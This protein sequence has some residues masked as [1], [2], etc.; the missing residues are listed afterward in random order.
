[1]HAKRSI[2]RATG[3]IIALLCLLVS[4][5]VVSLVGPGNRSLPADKAAFPKVLLVRKIPAS[6]ARIIELSQSGKHFCILRRSET[7]EVHSSDGVLAYSAQVPGADRAVISA[8]A[9]YAMVFSERDPADRALTFVDSNGKVCWKMDAEGA[10]WCADACDAD[11]G[12]RFAVGTA[13]RYVY[14]IDIGP[15]SRRYRRWRAPGAVVSLY[16]NEDDSL[17]Y[18]TWQDSAVCRSTVRGR[19][20]WRE[21]ADR[22]SA[23]QMHPLHNS[24]RALV[25][26]VPGSYGAD[27]EFRLLDDSGA[28]ILRGDLCASENARIIPAPNG[29]YICVA[30]RRL[31]I[32][33]G[34]SMPEKHAVLIDERG[35]KLWEKGSPFFQAEPVLVTAAGFVLLSDGKNA[36]F[37]VSPSGEMQR[38]W[39]IPARIEQSVASRD[40]SRLLLKCRDGMLYVLRVSS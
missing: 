8:D 38:C 25:C 12:A 7:I 20:L 19:T 17:T 21:D 37:A 11:K 22:A 24:A 4:C 13:E 34:K 18:G 36:L 33:K 9:S 29:R 31:I 30:S 26:S 40:G 39:K 5:A 27:G 14:I 1:M 23:Q 28:T 15:R 3:I 2:P 10:V 35:G 6:D 32:H 16:A